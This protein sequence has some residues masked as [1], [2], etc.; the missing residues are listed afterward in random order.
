MASGLWPSADPWGKEFSSA[1]MPEWARLA[2]SL[3]AGGFRGVLDG[4]QGDQEWV[5]KTFATK[6]FLIE[7]LRLFS[8]SIEVHGIGESAASTVRQS[9]RL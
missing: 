5:F 8:V 9:K 3:L 4:V 6:R 7:R 2:G 1:Y